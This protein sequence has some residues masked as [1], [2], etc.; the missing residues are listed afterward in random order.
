MTT[1]NSCL[2]KQDRIKKLFS[3]CATPQ[4]KYEKIIELGRTLAP[5]PTEFKTPKYLVKGCQSTMYLHAS[6]QEGRV[7][8]SAFSEALISAGLAALLLAIYDHE[9]PETILSCPLKVLD[10][11]GLQAS[12]SPGRSNGFDSLLKRIKQ[13]AL[14]FLI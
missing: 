13:E 12:L 8:F 6:L 11:L 4:Q 5:Y 1:F 7:T 9:L 2:E 10:E 3:H 14:N